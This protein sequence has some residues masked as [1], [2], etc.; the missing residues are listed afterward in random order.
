MAPTRTLAAASLALFAILAAPA[1]A[2]AEP[3]TPGSGA[4]IVTVA[5]AANFD[6]EPGYFAGDESVTIEIV[7]EADG[8][9]ISETTSTH[10]AAADGSLVV[11]V[12]ASGAA[13][14]YELTSWGTSSPV[15]GPL[16]YSPSDE[17]R[18]LSPSGETP[19][20]SGK[21][22]SNS[23][24]EA[25]G[26]PNTG[27]DLSALWLSG[28]LLFTGLLTLGAVYLVRRRSV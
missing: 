12:P 24:A 23:G 28:G 17:C 1:P 25:E 10:T 4:A 18:G 15:R 22:L 9:T 8:R 7:A 16:L 13:D 2:L 3:Y 26:L 14:R 27:A 11:P 20:P 19:G 21:G 6:A 5:C